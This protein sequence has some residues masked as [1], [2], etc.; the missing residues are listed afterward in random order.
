MVGIRCVLSDKI[1]DG[2]CQ[3]YIRATITRTYRPMLKT[4]IFVNPRFFR[5][6]KI[7]ENVVGRVSEKNRLEVSESKQKLDLYCSYLESLVHQHPKKVMDKEWL[8][9]EMQKCR[10]SLDYIPAT[11]RRRNSSSCSNSVS[12]L[13]SSCPVHS[14]SLATLS[15]GIRNSMGRI[16]SNPNTMLNGVVPMVV[17]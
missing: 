5:N 8:R 10:F 13:E 11:A 6:G 15:V 4:D 9:V 7:M 17:L 1:T 2:K 3:I 16:A 12:L 14:N